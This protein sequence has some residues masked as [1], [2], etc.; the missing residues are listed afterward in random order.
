[1]KPIGELCHQRLRS[2]IEA[3]TRRSSMPDGRPRALPA[4]L[5]NDADHFAADRLHGVGDRAHQADA[6]TAIDESDPC[7]ANATPSRVAALR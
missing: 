3:T 1:M 4:C 6:G 7:S 2:C 5:R